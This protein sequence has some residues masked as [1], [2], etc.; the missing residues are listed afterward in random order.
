MDLAGASVY[1][2]SPMTYLPKTPLRPVAAIL[3]LSLL[4]SACDN[5]EAA[6]PEAAVEKKTTAT[7]VYVQIRR[8]AADGALSEA[9]KLTDD[10]ASY[11]MQMTVARE[12]MG[13][14]VFAQNMKNAALRANI[15]GEHAAGDFAMVITRFTA[16]GQSDKAANFF[17]KKGGGFVEMVA[18]DDSV[19]CK[20]VRDFHEAT[21][22]KDAEIGN[23]SDLPAE[24]SE[25]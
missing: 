4:F 17:R 15:E 18:P 20:L 23:C 7:D 5:Q 13:Q 25:S 22:D 11:E 2:S 3:A 6:T 12:R 1:C 21:G 19:P 24:E 8:L 14:E 9:A 10:P 16:N